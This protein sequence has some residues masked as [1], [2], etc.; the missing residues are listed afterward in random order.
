MSP[1]KVADCWYPTGSASALTWRRQL[2][3]SHAS[4]TFLTLG[5]LV[6]IHQYPQDSIS[7]SATGSAEES[8]SRRLSFD[9][10]PQ[11]SFIDA[12]LAKTSAINLNNRH[13]FTVFS[14]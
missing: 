10:L 6:S 14:L 9:R 13:K 11:T 12:P 4:K 5:V 8:T 2:K 7:P 1:W 3:N